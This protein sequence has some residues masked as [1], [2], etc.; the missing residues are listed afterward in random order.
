M[1]AKQKATSDTSNQV[2]VLPFDAWREFTW[3]LIRAAFERN[4]SKT[5]ADIKAVLDVEALA[6]Y[7]PPGGAP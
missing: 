6:Q 5:R 4:D 2:V 7:G 3:A 1:P